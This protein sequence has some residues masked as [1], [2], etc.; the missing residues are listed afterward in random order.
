MTSKAGEFPARQSI[1]P[2]LQMSALFRPLYPI[3]WYLLVSQTMI[4]TKISF[5]GKNLALGHLEE[6]QCDK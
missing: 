5:E 6:M 4:V 1:T 3:C 2:V